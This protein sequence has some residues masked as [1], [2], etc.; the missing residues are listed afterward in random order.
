MVEHLGK[1]GRTMEDKKLKGVWIASVERFGYN[2]TVAGHTEAEATKALKAE[3]CEAFERWNGATPAQAKKRDGIDYL[4]NMIED[5]IV[6]FCE[7][8]KV[9][10]R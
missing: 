9:E 8:G 4:N 5:I 10:W 7:F 2:L 3:Y 6:E 1:E